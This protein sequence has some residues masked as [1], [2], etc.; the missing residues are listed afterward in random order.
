MYAACNGHIETVGL[1]LERAAETNIQDNVR[2][3][4]VSLVHIRVTAKISF[5]VS[6]VPY[7]PSFLLHSR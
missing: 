4:W 1:L 7:L 6:G 3:N 5:P 2:L